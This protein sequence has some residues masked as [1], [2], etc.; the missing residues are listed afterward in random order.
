MF[1]QKRSLIKV[2]VKLE[3]FDINQGFPVNSG[4]IY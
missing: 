2:K 1:Y 4:A 3:V